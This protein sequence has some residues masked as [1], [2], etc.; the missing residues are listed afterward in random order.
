MNKLYQETQ[1]NNMMNRLQQMI[2][3]MN[4]PQEVI[5]DPHQIVNYLVQSGQI[6]QDK[7][8]KAMQMAQQMGIKV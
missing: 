5:N 4:V 6:S 8:N 3:K 7:L 1:S 2:Q